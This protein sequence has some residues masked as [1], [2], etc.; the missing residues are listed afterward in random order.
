MGSTRVFTVVVFAALVAAHGYGTATVA[1]PAHALQVV[2]PAARPDARPLPFLYDLY[3][4]RG[5][6]GTAVVAAYAVEAGEL[7]REALAHGVRY[8]FDVS[9][10]LL[11]EATGSFLARHDSV[12]VDLPRA[13]PRDHLLFT[14]IQLHAPP[15]ADA[16]HRVIMFNATVP[17]IGQLYS[18]RTEIPD[19]G[20]RDLMLS[21]I[22]LGQ[23]GAQGGWRRGDATLALLPTGQFPA[24]DFDVYYEIYNMPAGAA[25][26]TELLVERLDAAA[27]PSAQVV[28]IAFNGVAPADAGAE[29][30]ELRRVE[31]SLSRGRYRVTARVTELGSGSSASRSRTFEV[32]AARAGATLVPAWPVASASV[33]SR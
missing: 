9:L 8:R 2:G 12:Y 30:A 13:L 29:L 14:T 3:T 19:Y 16:L 32:H 7:E 4:F 11:D 17:G 27:Q 24:S 25:Y 21:D 18:G 33:R 5:D 23:P 15:S 20:G 10:G 31:T 28:R 1:P 6:S 26:R 22:A